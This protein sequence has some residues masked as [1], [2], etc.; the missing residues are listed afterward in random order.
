[1]CSILRIFCARETLR[2]VCSLGI[3]L[4]ALSLTTAHAAPPVASGDLAA[5]G[6]DGVTVYQ[7]SG[8]KGSIPLKKVWKPDAS[9][10]TGTHVLEFASP[11]MNTQMQVQ[12]KFAVPS[13]MVFKSFEVRTTN[14]NTQVTPAGA[15]EWD[16]QT[17]IDKVTVSPWNMNRVLQQ[18]IAQLDLGG[19]NF[20]DSATFDLVAD[21]TEIVR[22][23][24]IAEHP[25]APPG[26]AASFSG[27][28]RPRTRVTAYIV[29]SERKGTG[30]KRVPSDRATFQ[31]AT[32]AAGSKPVRPSLT[33]ESANS[34]G[35]L[36]MP[37]AAPRKPQT[38]PAGD[39]KA[40]IGPVP[41]RDRF[42]RTKPHVNVG[43]GGSASRKVGAGKP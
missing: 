23:D 29:A 26:S 34:A 30:I 35:G 20:K 40:T 10:D 42:Y 43:T 1:M 17:I 8:L 4:A 13:G 22:G 19:G 15:D 7:A 37:G 24:G 21:S 11:N 16:G 9:G 27:S 41:A 2:A 32:G 5:A 38:A 12:A 31:P 3:W 28:F 6:K 25:N 18:C 14:G 36:K 39:L 33:R